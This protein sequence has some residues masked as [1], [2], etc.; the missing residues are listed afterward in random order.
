MGRFPVSSSPALLASSALLRAC[1]DGFSRFL[2]DK[3]RELWDTFQDLD[4]NGD[5]RLDATEIRAA[6]SRSGVEITPATV[7]DLVRHLAH[8]SSP[9]RLPQKETLSQDDLYITFGE[10][11]DFLIMLPRRATPFEIYKCNSILFSYLSPHSERQRLRAD[12]ELDYQVKTRY[13]D[14]RGAARVDKEGDINVSFPRAPGSTSTST[15]LFGSK[16]AKEKDQ[17]DVDADDFGDTVDDSAAGVDHHE[18]WRFLLAGGVAGAG[19][20]CLC[21]L[22]PPPTLRCGQERNRS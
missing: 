5:G 3:E 12:K 22:L 15:A 13:S 19:T 9:E 14:G 16:A 2:W 7:E 21:S 8:G 6:L 4:K 17:E 18:A 10:F 1:A 11:R 20:S